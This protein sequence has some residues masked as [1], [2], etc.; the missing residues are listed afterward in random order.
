MPDNRHS[1]GLAPDEAGISVQGTETGPRG[2]GH[3]DIGT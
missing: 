3:S 1:I 2:I